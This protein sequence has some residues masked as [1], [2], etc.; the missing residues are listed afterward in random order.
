MRGK[1]EKKEADEVSTG[2]ILVLPALKNDCKSSM[3]FN[4]VEVHE[5]QLNKAEKRKGTLTPLTGKNYK[6]LLS[7]LEIRKNKL[8]DLKDKDETKA[9]EMETKMRW[10][11]VLY[12]AEG[13]KIRDDEDRLRKA[14]KR[15]EQR[16]AQCQRQWEKR[17]EQVVEKMQQ[18]QDKRRKNIQKK[19]L[20]KMERKKSKARKR[21]RVLP[22]DL[23]KAGLQMSW[24]WQ[25]VSPA[26]K[27]IIMAPVNKRCC[28]YFWSKT[29]LAMIQ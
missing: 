2:A 5:K 11:N 12:K 1:T 26:P 20:A 7:R 9:L 6:Q 17:T 10:T 4:K 18:R 23:E 8:E 14:L 27:W 21:G 24:T 19:K 22:E 25:M 16:K 3:T 28:L 13:V 15:K 29:S